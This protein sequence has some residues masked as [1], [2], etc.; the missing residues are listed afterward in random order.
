MRS[1]LVAAALLAFGC[2]DS[3]SPTMPLNEE[4]VEA[5][6]FENV[7]LRVTGSAPA[8]QIVLHVRGI[9]PNGC[10]H[11]DRVSQTPVRD[12]VVV[13]I[14]VRRPMDPSCSPQVRYFEEDIT[15]MGTYAPGVYKIRVNLLTFDVE[16]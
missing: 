4:R 15:L 11:L 6:H 5:M 9:L 13:G 8:K 14:T 3:A 1:F 7:D 12:G 10:A 2:S 16:V